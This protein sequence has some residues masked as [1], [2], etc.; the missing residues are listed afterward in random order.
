MFDEVIISVEVSQM[1][2]CFFKQIF[3]P[4]WILQVCRIKLFPHNAYSRFVLYGYLFQCWC[5]RFFQNNMI[6]ICLIGCWHFESGLLLYE[7]SY[8]EQELLTYLPHLS[9]PTGFS[10]ICVDRSFVFCEEFCGLL[11]VL[12]ILSVIR[13]RLLLYSNCSSFKV[14]TLD[15]SDICQTWCQF[16]NNIT[17]T[18]FLDDEIPV[19]QHQYLWLLSLIEQI[20][21]HLCLDYLLP[22]YTDELYVVQGGSFVCKDIIDDM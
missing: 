9:S 19:S 17:C 11:C 2:S 13:F 6:Y 14:D 5:S 1:Y 20:L 21:I 3:S 22:S 7:E 18:R 12:F 15:L 4:Q 16:L 8:V 10:G